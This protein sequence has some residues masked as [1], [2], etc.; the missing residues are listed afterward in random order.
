MFASMTRW[1]C[2][3]GITASLFATGCSGFIG[4]AK[5]AYNQGRYL[6]AAENLGAHEEDL[7]YLDPKRQLEYGIYRGCAL[8]MLHDEANAARWLAYARD[9]EKESPGSMRPES[10]VILE[11]AEWQLAARR[12]APAPAPPI[13]SNPST[14]P[15][16]R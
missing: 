9:I 8:L 3:L 15:D 14:S 1:L 11:Q 5:K 10:R 4:S 2:V 6:E 12:N 13:G 16:R 7:P